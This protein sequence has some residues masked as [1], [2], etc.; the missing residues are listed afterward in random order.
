MVEQKNSCVGPVYEHAKIL[1]KI[2]N[3]LWYWTIK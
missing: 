3:L 2:Y 1:P